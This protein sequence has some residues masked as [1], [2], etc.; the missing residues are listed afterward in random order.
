MRR[1]PDWCG[2]S[3]IGLQVQWRSQSA[4]HLPAMLKN[5]LG[6][7]YDDD[8]DDDDRHNHDDYENVKGSINSSF[9]S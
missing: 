4:N 9:Q 8:H 7:V 5:K 2:G 6:C 3:Q 1:Q